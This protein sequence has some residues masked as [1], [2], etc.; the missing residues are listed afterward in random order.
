MIQDC[1]SNNVKHNGKMRVKNSTRSAEQDSRS[2]EGGDLEPKSSQNENHTADSDD[3]NVCHDGVLWS[4]AADEDNFHESDN[5]VEMEEEEEEGDQEGHET[6]GSSPIENKDTHRVVQGKRRKCRRQRYES[7]TN[8]DVD[9]SDEEIVFTRRY[10]EKRKRKDPKFRRILDAMVY[11]QLQ[12]DKGES[13]EKLF[14]NHGNVLNGKSPPI[15]SPSDTT[16]YTPAL[17]KIKET[18]RALDQISNFV[19]GIR[20]QNSS[21]SSRDRRPDRRRSRSSRSRSRS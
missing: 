1:D 3:Q 11:D 6:T 2:E 8:E 16:L 17:K 10:L 13:P 5:D 12:S 9:D 21:R 7:S 15:K 18:D 19:E 14:Q 4:V 20:L